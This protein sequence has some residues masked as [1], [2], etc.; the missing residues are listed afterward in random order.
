MTVTYKVDSG[1]KKTDPRAEVV[2]TVNLYDLFSLNVCGCI[3]LFKKY[4]FSMS[5]FKL[6]DARGGLPHPSRT[7]RITASSQ[8]S[9]KLICGRLKYYSRTTSAVPQ[10]LFAIF[11]NFYFDTFFL[12]GGRKYNK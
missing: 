12:G 5:D 1:R 4:R 3:F 2:L 6:V 11:L 8:H 7:K 9:A 10:P